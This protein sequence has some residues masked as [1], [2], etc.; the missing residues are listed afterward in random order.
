MEIG[1]IDFVIPHTV[2]KELKKLKKIPK[3]IHDAESALKF[4]SKFEKLEIHGEF[5][6][7]KILEYVKKN[8][9]FVGTLDKTLK[10]KVKQVGG[11]IISLSNDKIILES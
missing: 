10:N 11:S 3:K 5:A 6:D 7:Q 4:S 8:G 1:N 2:I 9:G